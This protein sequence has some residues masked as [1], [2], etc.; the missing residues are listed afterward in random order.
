MRYRL[1]IIHICLL[2]RGLPQSFGRVRF[3]IHCS[4]IPRHF[5]DGSYLSSR[6]PLRSCW[7]YNRRYL[8]LVV[9]I[10]WDICL[11]LPRWRRT[12]RGISDVVTWS[13]ILRLHAAGVCIFGFLLLQCRRPSN[14]TPSGWVWD[15]CSTVAFSPGGPIS[16]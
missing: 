6:R 13:F 1:L 5:P 2:R 16:V 14:Q 10:L 15:P 11:R 8:R 4:L 3:R 12:R 7:D 9:G